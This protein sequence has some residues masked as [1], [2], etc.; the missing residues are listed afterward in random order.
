MVGAHIS[1][2]TP[3][4]IS[5][6][7]GS[8]ELGWKRVKEQ[9]S[10]YMETTIRAKDGRPV[11]VEVKITYVEHQGEE[12]NVVFARDISERKKLGTAL[13]AAE[14]A[15]E[16]AQELIFWVGDDSRLI[17]VNE[18]TC[19][20][21][22]YKREELIGMTIFDI[23]PTANRPWDTEEVKA[24]GGKM[25]FEAP[26]VTKSGEEFDVEVNANHV[27]LG[28][29]GEFLCVY[30]RDISEQKRA[31]RSLGL[32]EYSMDKAGDLIYWIDSDGHIVYANDA[33]CATSGYARE[34]LL[35]M[36][37]HD[38]DPWAPSPWAEYWERTR[39]T[40]V[41]AQHSGQASQE[42]R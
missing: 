34:E 42:E 6:Q 32:A 26:Y 3:K 35:A 22:G 41:S 25:V 11:P 29:G 2:F 27:D 19:A 14:M 10:E 15:I 13:R 9:G 18:A 38:L 24:K 39:E 5:E 1:E 17:Y 12:Y 21:T 23:H 7:G 20:R 36:T 31:A 28:P 33:A 4:V 40:T 16:K 30:A 37:L 8:W